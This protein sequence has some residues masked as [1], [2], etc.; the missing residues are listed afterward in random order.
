MLTTLYLL[1]YRHSLALTDAQRE[2]SVFRIENANDV[3]HPL[4]DTETLEKVLE[5]GLKDDHK[6]YKDEIAMY[7]IN[8]KDRIKPE[9]VS[10]R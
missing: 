1:E 10:F 2:D 4:T 8:M 3:Y 6:R 5:Q 7:F 9:D